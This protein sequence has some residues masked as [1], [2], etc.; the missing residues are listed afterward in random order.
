MIRRMRSVFEY[1]IFVESYF[2]SHLWM[3]DSILKTLLLTD[4]GR[5]A[6]QYKI[7]CAFAQ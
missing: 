1:E 2:R 4:A 5:N 7:A 3:L 6:G